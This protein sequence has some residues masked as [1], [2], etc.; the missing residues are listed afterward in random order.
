VGSAIGAAGKVWID[1]DYALT[2]ELGWRP[3]GDGSLRGQAAYL[4]H[5]A[6][7]PRRLSLFRDL[8]S[9]GQFLFYYGGGVA[10]SLLERNRLGFR[11]PL[12][13]VFAAPASA[14]WDAFLEVAPILDILPDADW[15]ATAFAG[16][17]YYF[18]PPPPPASP[19]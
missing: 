4:V 15:E 17:R 1:A 18:D 9:S 8:D 16:W 19:L 6:E 3:E 14:S 11:A 2:G 7:T 13:L 10:V 12:G 5:S